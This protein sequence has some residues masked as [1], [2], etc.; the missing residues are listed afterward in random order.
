MLWTAT[1]AGEGN[2]LQQ[3]LAVNAWS[4]GVLGVALPLIALERMQRRAHR[5]YELQRRQTRRGRASLSPT[6]DPEAL[7]SVRWLFLA[8]VLAWAAGSTL[9][10]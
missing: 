8:S 7:A 5:A 2:P 4:M 6:R 1:A 10:L 3:C 9:A